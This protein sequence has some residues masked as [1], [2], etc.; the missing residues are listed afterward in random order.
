MEIYSL[1]K[2][3]PVTPGTPVQL[4]T[5]DTIKAQAVF[6]SQIGGTTGRVLLGRV[7][8]SKTTLAGVIKPFLPPAASGFLDSFDIEADDSRNCIQLSKYCVDADVA[9]EG[10]VI[11]YTVV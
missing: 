9:N 11:S 8:M 3:A 1:G 5:D 2:I 7:G 4:T 10:L 6:A